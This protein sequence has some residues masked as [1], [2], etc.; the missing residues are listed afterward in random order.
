MLNDELQ[1]SHWFKRLRS[2]YNCASNSTARNNSGEK[3]GRFRQRANCN[4]IRIHV[5]SPILINQR[6][7]NR[8]TEFGIIKLDF[9]SFFTRKSSQW[10]IVKKFDW[11]EFRYSNVVFGHPEF[12]SDA[13]SRVVFLQIYHQKAHTRNRHLRSDAFYSA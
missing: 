3:I 6:K 7:S 2:L 13:I 10:R 12:V 4:H 1:K 11:V 9:S 8:V 5:R